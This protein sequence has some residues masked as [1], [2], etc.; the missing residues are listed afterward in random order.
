MYKR[1]FSPNL[2]QN[3][4]INIMFSAKTST[5]ASCLGEVFKLADDTVI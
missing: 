4:S 5:V 3:S 2:T 1:H